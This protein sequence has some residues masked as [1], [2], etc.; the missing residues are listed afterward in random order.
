[1]EQ[2]VEY[3]TNEDSKEF[4]Q[5]I[6]EGVCIRIENG[7]VTPILLKNKNFIFK[8]LEGIVKDTNTVDIEESN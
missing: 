7:S 2:I 3:T 4:P 8:V 6:R 5:H 1:M